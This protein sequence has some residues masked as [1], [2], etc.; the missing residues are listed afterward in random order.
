MM[1]ISVF[2]GGRR[3]T[4]ESIKKVNGKTINSLD[5]VDI[6]ILVSKKV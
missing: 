2:F 5:Y 1:L 6:K 3:K 4:F